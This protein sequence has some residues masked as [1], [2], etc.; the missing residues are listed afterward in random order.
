LLRA[1]R[2]LSRRRSWSG[3]G[4]TGRVAFGDVELRIRDSKGIR[5]LAALLGSPGREIEAIALVGE[6]V[7][8][9]ARRTEAAEA[10]LTSCAG[11]DLGPTLDGSEPPPG[12]THRHSPRVLFVD[13][14]H[15]QWTVAGGAC[16]SLGSTS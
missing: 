4:T 12:P 9:P 8:D 10:G 2:A 1:S 16:T 13:R 6:R 14:S 5:Y 3:K 15:S 7:A 11:S